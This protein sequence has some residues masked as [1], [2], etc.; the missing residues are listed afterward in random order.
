LF[1]HL[2]LG[3]LNLIGHSSFFIRISI[4]LLLSALASCAQPFQS[5]A[6]PPVQASPNPTAYSLGPILHQNLLNDLSHWQVESEAPGTIS[7]SN[8]TLSID[9]PKGCTLWFKQP[10]SG[11]VFIQYDARMLRATPPGPNDRVSDLNCFWMASDPRAKSQ[12]PQDFFNVPQRTGAFAT[13]NQLLTYYVG[14]GG[15]TNSTTRF[16]RYIGDASNRPI[17]LEHDLTT[18]LLTPNTWQ[19]IQ[20]VACNHLIEYYC[21]GTRIFQY[22]D[23]NPY[24]QGYFALRTTF[25]H[26]EVKNLTIRQLIPR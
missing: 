23:P 5:R 16:R 8:G 22:T 6:T 12:S 4:A 19:T 17:L 15:N 11:N 10:L 26:M 9:V 25:N 2:E 13:Y 1:G 7:V 14:Q 21:D 3:H 18:H 24:T 20:L